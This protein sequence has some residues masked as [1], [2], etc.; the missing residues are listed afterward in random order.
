[1]YSDENK[2]RLL[3]KQLNYFDYAIVDTSSLMEDSFPRLDGFPAKRPNLSR[4]FAGRNIY[5]G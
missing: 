2:A 5:P 3:A 4:R 1:M